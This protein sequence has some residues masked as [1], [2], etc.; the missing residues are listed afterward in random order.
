MIKLVVFDI[1]GTTV[2]ENNVVY[3]TLRKAINKAGYN[4]SLETVL[5]HGAGKEKH[6][7][8]KDII[9]LENNKNGDE[10]S[11]SIFNVFSNL[12]KMKYADLRVRTYP[13]TEEVFEKLKEND[14]KIVLNTGYD[15]KTAR[16]LLSKLKWEKGKHYDELITASDVEN[17]RPAPD[18]INLAMDFFDIKDS[19]EVVKVGDSI[20]DIEEGKAANCGITIGVTTGAHTKEQ[21][22]SAQPTYIID[23]L[24]ELIQKIL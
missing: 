14:I 1:A 16:S 11:L 22:Q 7:A 9:A 12:L 8:I 17:S 24:S 6:Q 13:N 23:N 18:M 10:E 3:K 4:F 20:I 2:N 5:E 19:K 15:K 21:L